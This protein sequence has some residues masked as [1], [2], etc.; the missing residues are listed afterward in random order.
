[1]WSSVCVRGDDAERMTKKQFT[2]KE[3]DSF[4]EKVSA[5]QKDGDEAND[6]WARDSK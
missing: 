5:F 4:R 1:M 2:A 3:F 6:K